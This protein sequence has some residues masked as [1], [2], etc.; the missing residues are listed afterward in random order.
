MADDLDIRYGKCY[1][2]EDSSGRKL[3]RN[4]ARPDRG[5]LCSDGCTYTRTVFRICKAAGNWTSKNGKEVASKATFE[6][7][8]QNGLTGRPM[9]AQT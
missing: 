2:T 5:S 9:L 4:Y 6:L 8:D 7:Q 3:G 1:F